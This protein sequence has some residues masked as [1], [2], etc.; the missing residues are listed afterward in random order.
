MSTILVVDDESGNVALIRRVMESRGYDVAAAANGESGIDEARRIQPDVIVLDVN[1]G[2]MSGFD[3]CRQLKNDAAT[4][5]IP[6][7]L[8]TGSDL[9]ADRVRGLE[10]GADVFLIK[11][12][13][14]GELMSRVD[15]LV[16]L[17]QHRDALR[18]V[19]ARADDGRG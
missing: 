3:A 13:D 18:S 19:E 1:M 5:L 2:G 7:V 12:F 6:I 11:P 15:A 10:S 17:K 4:R 8:A 14:L 9:P 16:R